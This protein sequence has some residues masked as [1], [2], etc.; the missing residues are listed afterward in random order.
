VTPDVLY[1]AKRRFDLVRFVAIYISGRKEAAA[2]SRSRNQHG[3][4]FAAD[5]FFQDSLVTPA[6]GGGGRRLAG[7]RI[8]TGRRRSFRQDDLRSLGLH[9][10]REIS[11][12]W[13]ALTHAPIRSTPTRHLSLH[14]S[15]SSSGSPH[16]R[17][18]ASPQSSKSTTF[19]CE[20]AN[21]W[22]VHEAT[23]DR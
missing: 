22:I 23:R 4:V 6:L 16:P 10:R 3:H 13:R 1:S 15:L 21:D 8:S 14:C 2:V 17:H 7:V 5:F 18:A 12:G 11:Q 20:G 9:V 19:N